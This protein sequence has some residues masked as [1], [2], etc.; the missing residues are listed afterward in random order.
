MRSIRFPGPFAIL[1][2]CLLALPACDEPGLSR[3]DDNKSTA[4]ISKDGAFASTRLSCQ[5]FLDD[6]DNS[7]PALYQHRAYII[8]MFVGANKYKVGKASY[9]PPGRPAPAVDAVAYTCRKKP[10]L[11]VHQAAFEVVDREAEEAP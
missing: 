9:F 2:S 1:I 5:T 7:E 10:S 6:F 11:N 3:D 4:A 8:G